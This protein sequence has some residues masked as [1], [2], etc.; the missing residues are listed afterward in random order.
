MNK[1]SKYEISKYKIGK[2]KY[3]AILKELPVLLY[4]I[5]YNIWYLDYNIKNK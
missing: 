4:I 2:Y 5:N 3:L 1:I